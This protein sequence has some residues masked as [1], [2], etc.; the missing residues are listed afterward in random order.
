M[1][2]EPA[3]EPGRTMEALRAQARGGPEKLIYERV[4]PPSPGIGDVLLKVRAVSF[5]PTEL[6]WSSTWVDR[7]GNAR[8][9]PIPARHLH[10]NHEEPFCVLEG[11]L[12]VRVGSRTFSAPSGSF[13]VMP[14]GV[15]H[16]PSNPGTQ[17]TRVLL[18]FS[19]AGMDRF[20]EEAAEGRMPLQMIPTRRS[21]RGS[22]PLPRSMAT[23]LR[24]FLWGRRACGYGRVPPL[25]CTELN[26]P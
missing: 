15:V 5:I 19:P 22:Q 25:K 4:L 1:M 3:V 18:M 2:N 11:E 14:R 21:W 7:A 8:P 20:F 9:A 13:M 10:L 26:G 23:S 6:D 12:R 24:S 17:P 16:Q